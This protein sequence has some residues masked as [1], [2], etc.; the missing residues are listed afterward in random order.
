MRLGPFIILRGADD[1]LHL[2]AWLEAGDVVGEHF[3]GLAAA[4]AFPVHDMP[5]ARVALADVVRAAG[6]DQHGD[7]QVAEAAHQ[8]VHVFLQQRL[9]AGDLDERQRVAQL[10]GEVALFLEFSDDLIDGHCL[11]AGERVRGV[12]VGAAEVAAGE[13]DEGARQPGKG[14]L[15][16]DA[17]VDFMNQQRVAHG[18]KVDS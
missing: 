18:Q 3:T 12:A 7:V 17:Q 8:R 15:A 11:A 16:L 9:T 6:L 4:G 1:E 13:A 14:A 2:V 10:A 5:Y